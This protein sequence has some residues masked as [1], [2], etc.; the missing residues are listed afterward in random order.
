MMMLPAARYNGRRQYLYTLRE[1]PDKRYKFGTIIVH[2]MVVLSRVHPEDRTHSRG[3]RPSYNAQY[4]YGTVDAA[5]PH[6]HEM[7]SSPPLA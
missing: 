7:A 1:L 6:D 2:N 3:W 5:V 4:R